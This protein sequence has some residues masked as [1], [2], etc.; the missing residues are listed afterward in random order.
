MDFGS[1]TAK[2]TS[3][4]TKAMEEGT[5]SDAGSSRILSVSE[6]EGLSGTEKQNQKHIRTDCSGCFVF[7]PFAGQNTPVLMRICVK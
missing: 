1:S 4:D 5:G 7:H 2:G 6:S 3:T